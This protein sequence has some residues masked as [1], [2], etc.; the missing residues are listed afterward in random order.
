MALWLITDQSTFDRTATFEEAFHL[1]SS[2]VT[3]D[4]SKFV[5]IGISSNTMAMSVGL[6]AVSVTYAQ[7]Q[8]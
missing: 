5:G 3:F 4:S 6:A 8:R 7:Y 1:K 2:N